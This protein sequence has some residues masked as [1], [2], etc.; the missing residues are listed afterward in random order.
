MAAPSVPS[1]FALVL[2]LAWQLFK[3]KRKMVYRKLNPLEEIS[4][5]ITSTVNLLSRL[6]KSAYHEIH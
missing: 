1:N 3:L 2:I 6:L 4:M 5:P